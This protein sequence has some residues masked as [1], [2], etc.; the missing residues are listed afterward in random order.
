MLLAFEAA[1]ETDECLVAANDAVTWNYHHDRISIVGATDGPRRPRISDP[2]SELAIGNRFAV[3]DALELAPDRKLEVGT[4]RRQRQIKA[5]ARAR[6]VLLELTA[7]VGKRLG[8]TR[9]GLD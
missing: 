9:D 8:A 2:V 7:E 6:E 5:R 4:D 3:R 1:A